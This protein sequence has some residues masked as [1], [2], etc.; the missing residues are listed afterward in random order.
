MWGQNL[1]VESRTFLLRM[2]RQTREEDICIL[3]SPN[4]EFH[5]ER[6]GI[7]FDRSRVFEGSFPANSVSELQQMLD[8]DQLKQLTQG[9]IG[10]AL[11]S[12]ELDHVLLAVQ[13]PTGWQSLN[14]PTGSSRKPFRNSLD[15]L[16]KWLERAKQQPHP[17]P[18]TVPSRCMPPQEPAAQADNGNAPSPAQGQGQA[19]AN[20]SQTNLYLMR[21][22]TDHY[23]PNDL[24]FG[25]K[26]ERS[27]VIVYGT[28]RYRMEKSKQEFNSS[29]RT[30]VFRDSLSDAQMQELQQILDAP[31]L[32]KLQQRTTAAGVTMREGEVTNLAIPRGKG[33]QILSFASFF[34]A[35]TQEKGMRDNTRVS[36]DEDVQAVKP[37]HRW[38]KTN[39]DERK[40]RAAKDLPATA[41]IPS[42][43]PE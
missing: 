13:R 37:L 39:I 41:C 2:E 31:E 35:R 42:T 43:Q 3:V 9:Q 40:V 5:L 7:G 29:M 38:I 23:L 4:G 12:E 28:R 20:T 26:V 36:V 19:S 18:N 10:M 16:V 32:V 14:F 33:L 1:A 34:G 24:N 17:L 11:V 22:V 21:I 25:A 30:E 6:I 15:P 8:N 27:C